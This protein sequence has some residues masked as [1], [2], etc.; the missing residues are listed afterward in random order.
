MELKPKD[1]NEIFKDFKK[2]S[3]ER[4]I[5]LLRAIKKTDILKKFIPISGIKL[6]RF[7][8]WSD[9]TDYWIVKEFGNKH[10][11]LENTFDKTEKNVQY[12]YLF[13]SFT[14][15]NPKTIKNEIKR[16][17][18]TLKFLKNILSEI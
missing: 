13:S 11:I 5:S 15:V 12:R 10:I 8:Y 3:L 2:I 16:Y 17:E 14:A 18:N 4:R 7:C 6:F 9:E 1:Y